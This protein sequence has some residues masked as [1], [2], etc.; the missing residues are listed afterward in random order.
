MNVPI[1]IHVRRTYSLSWII[2]LT[3]GISACQACM[4]EGEPHLHQILNGDIQWDEVLPKS[5]LVNGEPDKGHN[6]FEL[7]SDK[8]YNIVKLTMYPDGGI[9]RC[10]LYGEIIK[11]CK[12]LYH[13]IMMSYTPV[14]GQITLMPRHFKRQYHQMVSSKEAVSMVFTI[15]VSCEAQS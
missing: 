12:A 1:A 10:K 13:P 15:S 5:P 3:Y 4:L 11:V 8:E 14:A 7:K 6:Y 2:S 9:A